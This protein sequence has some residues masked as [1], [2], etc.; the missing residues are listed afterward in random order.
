MVNEATNYKLIYVK[1]SSELNNEKQVIL[2]SK[3]AEG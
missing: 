3:I 2:K 1:N